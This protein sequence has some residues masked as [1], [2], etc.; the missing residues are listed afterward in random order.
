M[1]EAE[2]GGR[3]K[4]TDRERQAERERERKHRILHYEGNSKSLITMCFAPCQLGTSQLNRD[5]IYQ[6]RG[7][8]S[9]AIPAKLTNTE[10]ELGREALGGCSSG[11]IIKKYL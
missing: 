8:N 4:Q 9:A 7:N 6:K 11:C 5:A 3:E 2:R 1:T 10:S